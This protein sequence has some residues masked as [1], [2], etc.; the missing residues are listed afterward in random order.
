MIDLEIAFRKMQVLE[1]LGT[2]Q[3]APKEV[4][5]MVF[6]YLVPW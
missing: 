4:A 2:F 6:L 5:S 1:L 3:L